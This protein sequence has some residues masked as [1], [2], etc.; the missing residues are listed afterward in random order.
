VLSLVERS[1]SNPNRISKLYCRVLY[2]VFPMSFLMEQAGGQAF[3]GK[4]R[5]RVYLFRSPCLDYFLIYEL[6]A[7]DTIFIEFVSISQSDVWYNLEFEMIGEESLS[8]VVS[9]RRTTLFRD[10][11]YYWETEVSC[12]ETKVYY[13]NCS[14]DYGMQ[15]LELVPAHIHDRSPIFL[16]SYDDVEE[17][18]AL[19]AGISA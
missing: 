5:V 13:T 8:R 7:F 14:G 10:V 9:Q 19:Y 15:A 4:Q 16:G 2:E 17:I 12:W 3:T 18:K 11:I 6:F 1:I